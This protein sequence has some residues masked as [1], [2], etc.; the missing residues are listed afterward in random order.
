MPRCTAP[1]PQDA[2]RARPLT[3]RA[4]RYEA[5]GAN[6]YAGMRAIWARPAQR[7]AGDADHPRRTPEQVP[8][9]RRLR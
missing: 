3:R 5:L 1:A 7:M 9:P 6:D 2:W 8:L 4:V